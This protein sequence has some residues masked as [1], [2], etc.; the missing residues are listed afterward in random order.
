MHSKAYIFRQQ[1]LLVDDDFQLPQVEKLQHDLNLSEDGEIIARDLQDD[2]AVPEGYQLVPIRQLVQVWSRQQFEQA[3]R[4]VQLLEWRRNH[5]FCSHCGHQT[6]Q[7][8]SQYTMICLACGYNQYPRVNPCVITIISRGTDEIL[9]A[10]NARNKTQMYSLIAG[11]VE[12]GETLEEAVRRETLE[13][14]GL[15]V[16]NIKYL[17]SQPWPFPSNLMM[18]FKAEY[19]AGDIQIQE[20]ELTDAQFFK[21]NQLPEIPFQGSIAHAMIM[22]VMNG[23]P[24]ADDTKEWL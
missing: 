10:K 12:V 14:V 7:H 21:F 9:L 17:A 13:E 22:H 18:A 15:Q 24:V 2:K 8:V 4:A 6:Q 16:K 11:F 23:T 20:N 3:S 19:H 1:Q 5:Q